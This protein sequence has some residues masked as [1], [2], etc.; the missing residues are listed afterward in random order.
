[1]IRELEREIWCWQGTEAALE[2]GWDDW[3]VPG[4]GGYKEGEAWTRGK[5]AK[6]GDPIWVRRP[7]KERTVR[8]PSHSPWFSF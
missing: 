5:K 2:G 4:G 6:T 1:M 3:E 8:C 7:K